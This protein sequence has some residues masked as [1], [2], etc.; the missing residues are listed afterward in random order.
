MVETRTELVTIVLANPVKLATDVDVEEGSQHHLVGEKGCMMT[1]AIESR[2]RSSF[3][4]HLK[5]QSW[6]K[7]QTLKGKNRGLMVVKL[8]AGV[9]SNLLGQWKQV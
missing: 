4:S 3:G 9:K 6:M 7:Q 8:L 5:C 2:H 1:G